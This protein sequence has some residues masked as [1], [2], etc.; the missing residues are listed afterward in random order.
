[1]SLSELQ[2]RYEADREAEGVTVEEWEVARDL[3]QYSVYPGARRA[4]PTATGYG[5]YSR[6]TPKH[7][8]NLGDLAP[9]TGERLAMSLW[10]W[11]YGTPRTVEE[12]SA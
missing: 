1:M 9:A 11:K 8:A 2:A 3:P 7:V 5:M 12:V 10:E 6:T 4:R